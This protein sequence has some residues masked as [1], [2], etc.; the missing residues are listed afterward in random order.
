M[1]IKGLLIIVAA[2]LVLS[3]IPLRAQN[4]V[5]NPGFDQDLSDWT[6]QDGSAN[7]ASLD[8]GGSSSSGSLHVAPETHVHSECFPARPGAYNFAYSSLIPQEDTRGVLAFIHWYSDDFCLGLAGNSVS[9]GS[10]W[11]NSAWDRIGTSLFGID[12]I[13]PEG[14]RSAVIQLFSGTDAYFDNILVERLEG[15]T[16][17]DCLNHQRFAVK[18]D[19]SVGH[20]SGHGQQKTLTPDSAVFSFFN[21]DNIELVVKVLD[22]CAVNGHY[23]VFIA[24]LT[25]VRVEVT[26]TDV[27]TG[28]TRTYSNEE[29]HAFQPVQDTS[30]FATCP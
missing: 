5:S 16:G 13:A 12:V 6:V 20:D 21:P 10:Y 22:G 25:N 27:A 28:L 3:T 7:W 15:C 17:Q 14:T 8:A 24:G 26:V 11:S 23:W 9:L 2:G 19:W 4:L 29:N 18:V 30:A 1:R